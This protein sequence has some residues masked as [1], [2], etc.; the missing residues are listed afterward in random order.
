M[1]IKLGHSQYLKEIDFEAR[2]FDSVGE[3]I[4]AGLQKQEEGG[5]SYR[6]A[7]VR[8]MKGRVS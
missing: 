4:E 8:R 5:I 2:E 7:E 3:I 1:E 6:K